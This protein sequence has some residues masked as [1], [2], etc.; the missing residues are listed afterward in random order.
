MLKLLL[1]YDCNVEV[2]LNACKSYRDLI[3]D[4]FSQI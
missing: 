3:R 2:A 1:I 4:V